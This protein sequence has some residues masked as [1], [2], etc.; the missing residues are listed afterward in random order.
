[1][2][3]TV[4]A[5]E[6]ATIKEQLETIVP[7]FYEVCQVEEDCQ[8]SVEDILDEVIYRFDGQYDSLSP[9]EVEFNIPEEKVQAYFEFISQY[10]QLA[11]KVA[12]IVLPT[13]DLVV[14]ECK[15]D[16]LSLAKKA[17]ELF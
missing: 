6:V 14:S 9:G 17:E 10:Y 3:I 12:K 8:E 13:V 11:F 4:T 15:E 1:M 16:F 7:M 5:N 2:K